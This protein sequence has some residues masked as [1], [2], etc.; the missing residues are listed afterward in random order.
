MPK[1]IDGD[2]LLKNIKGLPT[3]AFFVDTNIIIAYRDPISASYKNTA[4]ENLN[5]KTTELIRKL[6]SANI[7]SYTTFAVAAEYYK[8]I[9]VNS[10]AVYKRS[11]S[12]KKFVSFDSDD[13]KD[14]KENDLT[15]LV[16]WERYVNEFK[17][18]FKKTIEILDNPLKPVNILDSFEGT[19]IDFGDHLLYEIVRTYPKYKCIFTNDLDFYS[20]DDDDLYIITFNKRII[21]KAKTDKKLFNL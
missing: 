16:M 7:K 3:E 10:Y 15:F 1:V 18:P 6:I 4:L 9:Q 20:I 8:H 13:F 5:V 11:I 21:R 17:R 19:K 2:S 14:L 12:Q